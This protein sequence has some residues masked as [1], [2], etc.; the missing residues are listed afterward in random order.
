M[1]IGSAERKMIRNLDRL[2]HPGDKHVRKY[3]PFCCMGFDVRSSKKLKD[4]LPLCRAY[5]GQKTILPIPLKN[6][7]EFTDHHKS[8][9]HPIAIYA[10]CESVCKSVDHCE[11]NPDISSTDVKSIHQCSG[12]SYTVV[13][14]HFPQ[15]S[16][17]YKGENAGVKFL[18]SIL[19]EE[20]V[21]NDWKYENE[22]KN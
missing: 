13:S 8:L 4:H 21:I 11:S 5:G 16:V 6:I 17:K 7:Q 14:P 12:F 2:L 20:K 10:D 15:R 22:K 1:G 18:E 3:C 9:E 19:E